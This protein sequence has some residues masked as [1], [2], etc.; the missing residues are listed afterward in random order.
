MNKESSKLVKALIILALVLFTAISLY[1]GRYMLKFISEPDE[2]RDWIDSFGALAPLAY[3]FV[4]MLQI[5]VPMIPGEPVEMIAGYAFGSLE[6]TLLCLFAESLAAVIITLLVRKYGR[7]IVEVF[8][9]KEKID[10]MHFLHSTKHKIITF[11]TIYI[12][13]GTPKDLL[14]YYAGLTDIDLRI[15]LPIVTL[16]RFPGIITSTLA[17]DHFGD[18]KYLS[19]I[20]YVFIAG[21][22]SLIGVLIYRKIQKEEER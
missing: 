6:G 14:C 5:I 17:G 12:M 18:Q 19:A 3:I 16:G 22:M 11:A 2:F 20:M 4:T 1:M 10:S 9:T 8:F 15:L 13:P 21:L 7:K